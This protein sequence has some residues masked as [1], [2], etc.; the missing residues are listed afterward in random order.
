MATFTWSAGSADWATL[1]NWTPTSATPPGAL[2]QDRAVFN[3]IHT[4]RPTSYT[5][6][7]A[8][9]EAFDLASATLEA[10][11]DR[12]AAPTLSISGSL[13][14]GDLA[15]SGHHPTAITL[16]A[17]VLL[18]IGSEI[19]DRNFTQQAITIDADNGG[20][21]RSG[22]QH[23]SGSTTVNNLAVTYRFLNQGP[24]S[25]NIGEIEF[26]TGLLPGIT[27]TQHISGI[28]QGDELVFSGADFTGDT[29]SL[30]NGNE[31]TVTDI[32]DATVLTMTSIPAADAT[33]D[34][35]AFSDTIEATKPCYVKGTRILTPAG[36]VPIENLAA[37]H[38]V[39]TL[40]GEAKPIKRIGRRGYQGRFITGNRDLLPIRFAA[41]ALAD[42]KPN[43]E[44]DVSPK[45]AMFID[46]LLIPA[47]SLLNDISVCQLQ[48]VESVEYFYLEL[49]AHDVIFANGAAS[50]TF[51]DCDSRGMFH[52]A[53]DYAC[54]YPDDP[55]A[56]WQCCAPRVEPG[57]VALVAIR[58]RLLTRAGS[59]ENFCPRDTLLGNIERC[60]RIRIA[61]WV[62][63]PADPRQRVRLEIR[64]DGEVVGHVVA[65]RYRRDLENVG[66]LG[67]GC[68]SFS[69]QHPVTLNPFSG[70]AI[71][72]LRAADGAPVPGS[73]VM[74]S[75]SS[76]FD[77][78]SRDFVGR[79]LRDVAQSATK[80]SDLDDIIVHMMTES[81]ALL[82]ARAR[83]NV[84]V[85]ADATSIRERW[86]GLLPSVAVQQD[87]WELRPQ[88]LFIDEF[89]PA[90]GMSGGASA[91]IDHMRSL[92][93]LGFDVSF[94]ASR[95]LDDGS[96]RGAELTKLGIKP[97]SAP[98][99]GSIEEILRRHSGRM[100]L[101]YLHRAANA[102]A[103]SKLV[104]QVLPTC[105]IGLRGG[106]SASCA[107]GP[108]G[109][110]GKPPGN[111]AP[112]RTS[113]NRGDGRGTV[114]RCGDH[115]FEC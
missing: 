40:S 86:G 37:G 34:F 54:R 106:R 64:C 38:L 3:N 56:V 14:S 91:A 32:G 1:S 15:Y 81:E 18:D 103:Y 10:S 94:A 67:D 112:R 92:M 66:Y 43:H 85:R 23:E 52:H 47:E 9:G 75:V 12:H 83:L 95:D 55:G 44:L 68:C 99:Y 82:A 100:D 88:T 110:S 42:G 72:I 77:A 107:P 22:G 25:F 57:S 59:A 45:H 35:H 71:E 49:A 60:D 51:V 61:G 21:A 48:D 58:G 114:G 89:F 27:T 50:E 80:A 78:E 46:G 90:A 73:P 98:W 26:Q 33:P 24:T 13:L 109:V 111:L 104:R 79:M 36:E 19:S 97:L 96:R 17:S 39:V 53:I 87:A 105:T 29:V 115:P 30:S 6:S 102:A 20:V 8:T 41:G 93:R 28:A 84:G 5:V 101:V 4:G 65:D 63:D 113:T 108:P 16:H 76:H 11:H 69:F 74:L 7:I 2:N 62:F 70:H 31:L